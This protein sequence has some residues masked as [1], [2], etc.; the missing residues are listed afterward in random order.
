MFVLPVIHLNWVLYTRNIYMQHI[1]MCAEFGV[2]KLVHTPTL[3]II[4]SE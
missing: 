2:F 1:Y 4:G 3:I